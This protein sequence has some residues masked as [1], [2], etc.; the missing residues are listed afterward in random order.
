MNR[1]TLIIGTLAF[2]VVILIILKLYSQSSFTAGIFRDD[3]PVDQ[4]T[5]AYNVELNKLS[6]TY[7][8]RMINETEPD[9]S[10]KLVEEL[11][12]ELKNLSDAYQAFL[13]KKGVNAPPSYSPS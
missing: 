11:Q 13:S 10:L 1:D 7:N 8:T 3:M 12:N 2:I 4:A 5:V 6:T 9:K